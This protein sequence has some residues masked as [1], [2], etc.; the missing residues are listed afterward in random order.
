MAKQLQSVQSFNIRFKAKS[1][2]LEYVVL[3]GV[4]DDGSG[5]QKQ[6][7]NITNVK[8]LS[9]EEQDAALLLVKYAKNRIENTENLQAKPDPAIV[10]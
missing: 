7:S 4:A 3:A 5:Y 10:K 6:I 9:Q 2:D 1:L 8:D